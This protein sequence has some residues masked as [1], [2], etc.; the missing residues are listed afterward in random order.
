MIIDSTKCCGEN[1]VHY[2]P[3]YLG[4]IKMSQDADYSVECTKYVDEFPAHL[5]E[6]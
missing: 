6:D 4:N 2:V 5:W 3:A 1:P